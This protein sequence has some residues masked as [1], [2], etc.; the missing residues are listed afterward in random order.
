MNAQ[1]HRIGF[2][3]QGVGISLIALILTTCESALLTKIREASAPTVYTVTFE[4]LGAEVP[5]EPETM[6]VE[7]PARTVNNLPTQ[8]EKDGFAFGGW[9]AEPD[10]DGSQFFASTTVDADITVYAFWF[11]PSTKWTVTLGKA[12]GE[13]GTDSVTAIFDQPMPDATAP[14]KEGELFDGYFSGPNG[15]GTKYYTASMESAR[16]WDIAAHTQLIANWRPW[17]IG[18]TGPA[19]GIVFYDKGEFSDGWRYLEAAPRLTEA[20]EPWGGDGTEVGSDAQGTLIGTGAANTQAIVEKL[21]DSA[22]YA[23]RV[24]ADMD[25]RGYDDWFL[26]SKEELNR[27]YEN[28]HQEGMGGF[29]PESYWSSSELNAGWASAQAFDWEWQGAATKGS[30]LGVRAVRAF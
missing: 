18:E 9:W 8:P 7:P 6:S 26:P 23:A 22:K 21:G 4:S 16:N 30:S 28:L 29:A 25:Y 11:D 20:I 10:G 15:S 27:M 14:T 1:N 3:V 13:G 5:A 2:L 24:C 17:Q 12:G 19:G